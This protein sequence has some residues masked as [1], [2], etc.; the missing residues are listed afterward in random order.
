L[1]W[2]VSVA[3]IFPHLPN[4]VF[5]CALTNT[6][7]NKRYFFCEAMR[8]INIY[9]HSNNEKNRIPHIAP[10]MS[11]CTSVSEATLP[12]L[13]TGSCSASDKNAVIVAH[14]ALVRGYIARGFISRK[15]QADSPAPNAAKIIKCPKNLRIK[16]LNFAESTGACA[17]LIIDWILSLTNVDCL[18]LVLPGRALSTIMINATAAVQMSAVIA[19][20]RRRL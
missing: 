17:P 16:R 13:K 20:A 18:L 11:I 1:Y 14:A 5:A 9:A 19:R 6:A 10:V 3:V 4:S 8:F 12:V 7:F 2:Q 15:E